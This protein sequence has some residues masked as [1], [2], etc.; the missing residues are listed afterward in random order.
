MLFRSPPIVSVRKAVK[1][2][3]AIKPDEGDVLVKVI[4]KSRVSDFVKD[5]IV[6]TMLSGR[7]LEEYF[8]FTLAHILRLQTHNKDNSTYL[9]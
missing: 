4:S 6:K 2:K 8:K 7:Y 5:G 9:I 1:R 3:T